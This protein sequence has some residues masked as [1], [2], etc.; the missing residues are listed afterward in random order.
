MD[1]PDSTS[2]HVQ[3]S[4]PQMPNRRVRQQRNELDVQLTR[5][6][7]PVD[8]LHVQRFPVHLQKRGM[9]QHWSKMHLPLGQ[10]RWQ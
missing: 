6:R 8:F 7:L 9:H 3:P 1:Q 5:M 10:V 4:N 2:L